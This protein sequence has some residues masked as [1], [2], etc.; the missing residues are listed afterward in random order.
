MP[1][2]EKMLYNQAMI[3]RLLV[4]A[5]AATGLLR[6]K[7]AALRTFDYVLR[8]MRDEKGGFYSAQDADS[9]SKEGVE[10]EGHF[11][12]WEPDEISQL[13]GEDT[14]FFMNA[15]GVTPEGNFE[16]ANVLHMNELPLEASKAQNISELEYYNRLDAA[17]Q[18]IYQ[19]R[20]SRHAPHQDKKIVVAWN[21][22]M[23]ET[24][25]EAA[26]VFSRPDYYQAAQKAMSYILD[27]MLHDDGLKRISYEGSIGVAAQLPDHAGLANALIALYDYA[28]NGVDVGGHLAKAAQIARETMQRYSSSDGNAGYRMSAKSEGIGSFTPYDDNEIPSGNALALSMLAALSKRGGG[29]EFTQKATLLSAALSG[30]VL[31]AP[32][33]GGYT[34]L[35]AHSL[36]HGEIGTVR[37][38]A[39]GA[40]RVV[41]NIERDLNQ[42]E[43]VISVKEGWHINAN[44]PLEDYFIPTK[45][46]INDTQIT[47]NE[48]PEPL[49][50]SLKFNA[51][52]MAL[53]EGNIKLN[54]KISASNKGNDGKVGNAIL[55][56]QAC[57]DQICLLPEEVV[58]RIW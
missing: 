20:K 29:T 25:A 54:A 40:V 56:L 33:S 10:G 47:D 50:K 7:H 11:Y 5:W 35:S 58:V 44:V 17:N 48:Y 30:H 19:K 41:T 53:Y 38:L 2:F 51:K 39:E 26:S 45:L 9:L 15:L 31:D 34:L 28:Q 46:T 49:V 6:Y 14:N 55:S 1:H 3:G 12:V 18:K 21:A 43:F 36:S 57:S 16:G 52:P 42:I 22:V 32:V 4:R 24:L 13:L 37:F 27:E 8:E 23:I